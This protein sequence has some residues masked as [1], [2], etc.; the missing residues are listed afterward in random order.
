M[1]HPEFAQ[2]STRSKA[3]FISSIISG[4]TSAANSIAN[5]VEDAGR[6]LK[7]DAE[8]VVSLPGKGL[9]VVKRVAG[10]IVKMAKNLFDSF[11]SEFRRLSKDTIKMFSEFNV[12]KFIKNTFDRFFKLTESCAFRLSFYATVGPIMLANGFT[13][14]NVNAA[15][16]LLTRNFYRG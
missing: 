12:I 15:Y 6:T 11:M 14:L 5:V 13:P 2:L 3:K 9:T 10:K 16:N 4:I 1:R 7:E 8:T